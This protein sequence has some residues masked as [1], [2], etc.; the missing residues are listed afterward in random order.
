MYACNIHTCRHTH[1]HTHARTH[2][3]THTHTS[4]KAAL[5]L[6]SL[7]I[8]GRGTTTTQH[9]QPSI[10]SCLNTMYTSSWECHQTPHTLRSRHQPRRLVPAQQRTKTW[11]NTCGKRVREKTVQQ[12]P[13]SVAERRRCQPRA[14]VTSLSLSLSL[15]LSHP[16][17]RLLSLSPILSAT[18][19]RPLAVI[20]LLGFTIHL[21]L[22][23]F[24]GRR[25][26]YLLKRP[27]CC[28][29]VRKN[30]LQQ[31]PLGMQ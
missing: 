8:L 16:F 12:A 10:T 5:A 7:L 25:I 17:A 30:S 13:E 29:R 28:V 23:I 27:N 3:H 26:L 1:T 21:R 15:S 31:V 19:P 11:L 2:T 9:D 18:P 14:N 22:L 24:V 4:D 20:Y 6:Y